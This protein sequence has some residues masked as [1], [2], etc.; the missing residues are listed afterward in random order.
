M[1]TLTFKNGVL[2][3]GVKPETVLLIQVV[4]SILASHGYRCIVTSITDGE[5]NR[6]SL[7]YIG[8]AVDFRIRHISAEKMIQ[9]VVEIKNALTEEF[10]VILKPDHMHIEFQPKDNRRF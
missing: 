9:L 7:H 8:H 6:G 1:D 5:H 4:H 3:N 10:D 2:I